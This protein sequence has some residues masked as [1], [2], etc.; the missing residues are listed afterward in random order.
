MLGDVLD[1]AKSEAGKLLTTS[2]EMD[3]KAEIQP[4][5][6]ALQLLAKIGFEF[7]VEFDT[8]FPAKIEIDCVFS[9]RSFGTLLV[10]RSS[11]HR[12]VRYRCASTR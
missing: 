10:T 6:E 8:D 4:T 2:S 7:S 9:V 3:V 5:L 1:I 11:L 12:L